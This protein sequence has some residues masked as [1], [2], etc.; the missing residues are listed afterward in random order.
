MLIMLLLM[1]FLQTPATAQPTTDQAPSTTPT[2][3]VEPGTGGRA[4]FDAALAAARAQRNGGATRPAAADDGV[5]DWAFSDQPRW[6][7]S[8]CGASS[9]ETADCIRGARNRLAQARVARLDRPSTAPGPRPVQA[10]PLC[11][12]VEGRAPDGSESSAALVCSNGDGPNSAV[13]ELE[14]LRAQD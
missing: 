13:G 2:P 7:L 12:T 14:R 6:E 1:A 11:R 4:G 8:Q 9:P 10:R 5:P 3:A